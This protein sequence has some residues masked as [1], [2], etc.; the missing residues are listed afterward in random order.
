MKNPDVDPTTSHPPSDV[1]SVDVQERPKRTVNT[2]GTSAEIIDSSD[3]S[4]V[5]NIESDSERR[6]SPEY[7]S[8][9]E[10]HSSV[11]GSHYNYGDYSG[12]P[13]HTFWFDFDF[14]PIDNEMFHHKDY[15]PFYGG[16]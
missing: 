16:E 9:P 14:H 1:A 10:D 15:Y 13:D 12:T 3:S 7:E 11:N 6:T 5:N 2:S 4:V 8:T